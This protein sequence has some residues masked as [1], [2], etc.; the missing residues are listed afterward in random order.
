MPCPG[1]GLHVLGH[2]GV[3]GPVGGSKNAGLS[4]V[5]LLTESLDMQVRLLQDYMSQHFLQTDDRID[6]AVQRVVEAV[7]SLK[8]QFN[9]SELD[10]V[11]FQVSKEGHTPILSVDVPQRIE[12]SESKR[13]SRPRLEIRA[14]TGPVHMEAEKIDMADLSPKIFASSRRAHQDDEP[15]TANNGVV[16]PLEAGGKKFLDAIRMEAMKAESEGEQ[17][18]PDDVLNPS[19]DARRIDPTVSTVCPGGVLSPHWVGRL[20]WDFCVMFLVLADAMVLPFQLAFAKQSVKECSGTAFLRSAD[21]GG[22]TSFDVAWL[23]LT[24]MAFLLD[25]IINFCTAYESSIE[26]PDLPPG[27]LVTNR[28]KIVCTYLS[29]WFGIDVMS[30]IPWPQLAELLTAGANADSAQLAKLTK[31]VKFVRFLRLMRMLR[32][33]KLGVIWERIESR[34]GSMLLIQVVALLRVLFVVIAICHWNACIFWMIGMPSS[35]FTDILSDEAQRT[36]AAGPHWTTVMRS[37]GPNDDRLWCWLEQSTM[38]SY[39]FCF[40]WTL[41]VMRTMPA[42][43]TPVN[44]PERMFVLFFMFFALSAFAICIAQITQAFFKLSER[45]RIFNEEMAAVRMYLRRCHVDAP[46]QIRVKAYL[47]HLFDRRRIHT[48]ESILLKELPRDI[49]LQMRQDKI[50]WHLERFEL[51]R[52]LGDQILCQISEQCDLF[53]LVPGDLLVTQG[54]VAKAAWIVLSGR[55][56]V[57]GQAIS[58]RIRKRLSVKGFLPGDNKEKQEGIGGLDNKGNLRALEIIDGE[59]LEEEGVHYTQQTVVATESCEVLR[60]RKEA[61]M[62]LLHDLDFKQ[63]LEA[64]K[65]KDIQRRAPTGVNRAVDQY[66]TEIPENMVAFGKKGNS[67][68]LAAAAVITTG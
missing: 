46:L 57:A 45:R 33:A 41:G 14:S 37:H 25:I 20:M 1:Q 65:Q 40:Y 8:V 4:Y 68:A 10:T 24:S 47:R 36:Y 35:L 11:E 34:C 53:D 23:W 9:S 38:S 27:T 32:L 2:E 63:L 16:K 58:A 59:C 62:S 12:H 5:K 50:K 13:K 18:H 56:H 48:V 64:K 55:V 31:V 17:D 22:E 60:I 3:G 30:T 61:F 19:F 6:L 51:L 26:E 15:T 67:E 21:A 42:E 44:L 29:G 7:A 43:V 54:Q 49:A 28:R 66:G 39:M 52:G